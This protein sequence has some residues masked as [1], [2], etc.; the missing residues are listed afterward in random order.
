MP[1]ARLT[2][3]SRPTLPFRQGQS[4]E[5]QQ[6]AVA[7]IA[8]ELG[9]DR[10]S[11][12]HT[13]TREGERQVRGRVTGP[14]RARNDP[15]TDDWEQALANYADELEAHLDEFQG[16]GYTYENDPLNL[17]RN[18][19]VETLEWSRTPG[20]PNDLEYQISLVE[21]EGTMQSE[22]IERQNPTVN[23]GMSVPLRVD[24]LDLP[25]IREYRMEISIGQETRAVFDPE[26][27]RTDNNDV[28]IEEGEQRILSFEGTFTGTA[29][30][31]EQQQ[32]DLN[33]K[34]ATADP[35]TLTTRFPGYD[36]QGFLIAEGETEESRFG[37]T[38][39]HYRLEF[40]EG[41]RA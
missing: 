22:A 23:S 26:R 3:P 16:D 35:I 36:I 18:V 2:H 30:Q 24:G 12:V 31:R 37:I 25:G 28:I 39:N 9:V 21:G 27:Q 40:V 13:E 11:L 8:N 33:D 5:G 34:V 7:N 29:S 6:Q 17:S 15:D 38:S 20:Q 4:D 41:I 32:S 19:I 14:R 10:R 1:H